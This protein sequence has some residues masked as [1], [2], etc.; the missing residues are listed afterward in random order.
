VAAH[1]PG[2]SESAGDAMVFGE[3]SAD[4]RDAAGASRPDDS[5]WLDGRKD[6]CLPG[7]YP[8]FGNTSC[9][10]PINFA[11]QPIKWPGINELTNDLICT[12]IN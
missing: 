9:S 4:I 6:H 8:W 11:V 1:Q 3:N 7:E 12:G 2:G 5:G 10:I